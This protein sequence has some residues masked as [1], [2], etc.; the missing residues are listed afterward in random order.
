M[1]AFCWKIIFFRILTFCWYFSQN[2]SGKGEENNNLSSRADESNTMS[3]EDNATDD[4]IEEPIQQLIKSDVHADLA[5]VADVKLEA[6]DD[7]I[8]WADHTESTDEN[9]TCELKPRKKESSTSASQC[10]PMNQQRVAKNEKT[11]S[12]NHK[13][14]TPP[15]TNEN[16]DVAMQKLESMRLADKPKRKTNAKR[17]SVNRDS[18]SEDAM[19]VCSVSRAQSKSPSITSPSQMSS[20]PSKTKKKKSKKRAKAVNG[21]HS[22]DST[23][24]KTQTDEVSDV[25]AT[26]ACDSI[27]NY[28][29]CVDRTDK[30]VKCAFSRVRVPENE[31]V[32]I[33]SHDDDSLRYE[34]NLWYFL[35]CFSRYRS[36]DF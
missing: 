25:G 16:L 26:N 32:Y 15:S 19:D 27:K 33:N 18:L 24:C 14:K 11:N 20:P 7:V 17:Q 35:V 10:C 2:F 36:G 29:V 12:R 13:E 5:S 6:K 28:D 4:A 1:Y 34:L 21:N 9:E 31:R 23:T 8:S 30:N 22:D 3:E